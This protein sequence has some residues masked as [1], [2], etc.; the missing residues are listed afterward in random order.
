MM[1]PCNILFG[2]DQAY[3]NQWGINLCKSIRYFNPWLNIHVHIVNPRKHKE[4]DFVNYTYENKTF[5]S[6]QHKIGYLQCC[7]FLA[8]AKKFDD[9]ELVMTVDADSLCQKSFTPQQFIKSASNI[10][11]LRH[12]KDK[13]WLAG[14]I[15][16]G[17]GDFKRVYAN[18]LLEKPFEDFAPFHDQNILAELSRTY[19]FIEQDI[20]TPWMRYGKSSHRGIFMTLKGDEKIAEKYLTVYNK[21]LNTIKG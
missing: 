3:Y 16:F 10:T 5:V 17:T 18:R 2:C 19:N 4:L 14:M 9:K 1:Q 20:E 6:E 7:R 15:T 21:V 13:R 12:H 11:V 8:V